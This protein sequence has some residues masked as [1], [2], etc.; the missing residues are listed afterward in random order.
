M[1]GIFMAWRRAVLELAL[2]HTGPYRHY[3]TKGLLHVCRVRRILLPVLLG[4]KRGGAATWGEVARHYL[5][6]AALP[7]TPY[8]RGGNGCVQRCGHDKYMALLHAN[9]TK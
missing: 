2:V 6:P 1:A 8:L 5:V 7:S 9:P 4:I 3:T